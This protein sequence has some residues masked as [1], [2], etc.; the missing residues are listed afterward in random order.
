MQ[1]RRGQGWS[2]RMRGRTGEREGETGGRI[3]HVGEPGEL[4]R[5]ELVDAA[6]VPLRRAH[7]RFHQ[8]VELSVTNRTLIFI[9]GE[10]D[11]RS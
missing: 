9:E 4:L 11:T 1:G 3:Q 10:D 8:A 7:P 5:R 6:A 2:R